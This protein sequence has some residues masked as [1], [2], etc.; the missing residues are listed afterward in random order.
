MLFLNVTHLLTD[1][2]RLNAHG[3]TFNLTYKIC[4]KHINTVTCH[5]E[6]IRNLRSVTASV[7]VAL[8]IY[9]S[10]RF[11][12]CEIYQVHFIFKCI[13]FIFFLILRICICLF[14]ILLLRLNWRIRFLSTIEL[15][16]ANILHFEKTV[17]QIIVWIFRYL[18][19]NRAKKNKRNNDEIDEN[20]SIFW[21]LIWSIWWLSVN[22]EMG[23]NY[24]QYFSKHFADSISRFHSF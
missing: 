23:P 13:L 10:L 12:F 20:S 9:L 15:K 2:M 4:L 7:C 14:F 22:S 18:L 21:L 24:I 8:T 6:C 11:K 17:F 3:E 1:W 16:F 5:R 19:L